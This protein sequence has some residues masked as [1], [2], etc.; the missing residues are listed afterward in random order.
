MRFASF[1]GLTGETKIV[2]KE[3]MVE[4]A[5]PYP[6]LFFGSLFF[7]VE[8]VA[9]MVV[10][11]LF[12]RADEPLLRDLAYSLLTIAYN[13]GEHID[14]A[15]VNM[16]F[17]FLYLFTVMLVVDFVNIRNKKVQIQ[18]ITSFKDISSV[19][20]ANFP[21]S[22]TTVE[23]RGGYS[24]AEK[25]IVYMVVSSNE[26]KKV[27]PLVKKIDQHAFVT[28][29]SLVQAYGNFFIKPIE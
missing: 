2:P 13:K 3:G 1:D 12:R 17:S 6:Y 29:T 23:G 14:L 21:H 27:V 18:I 11:S 22:T 20:I 19:L 8:A 28:V 15:F 10:F 5:N 16:L 25:T 9:V 26:V 7:V 24:H 4:K